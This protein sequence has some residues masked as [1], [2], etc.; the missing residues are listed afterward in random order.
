M[1]NLYTKFV[2]FLEIYKHFSKDLVTESGNVLRLDP[3]PCFSN[4][5]VIVLG[6]ATES[7]E[8]DSE[9]WL[10]E[11][12]LKECRG[13]IPNL[14]SRRQFNDRHKAVCGLQ[15]RIRSQMAKEMDG[16]EVCFC[17]DS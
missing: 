13:L 2:K 7:E 12:R 15:K 9:N 11:S 4:L 8:I 10:F 1:C 14:I 17:I 16:G 6:M 5:E 3:V